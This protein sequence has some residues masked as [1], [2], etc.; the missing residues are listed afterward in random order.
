MCVANQLQFTI[1]IQDQWT[2]LHWAARKGDTDCVQLLCDAGAAV[3]AKD[4]VSQCNNIVCIY[5][6][7][8][9]LMKVCV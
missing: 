2:A 3:D 7:C 5:E 1:I 8:T 9:V 6:Y 4:N